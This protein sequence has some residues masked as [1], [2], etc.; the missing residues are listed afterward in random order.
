MAAINLWQ[1]RQDKVVCS[2]TMIICKWSKIRH[3]KQRATNQNI[4]T[5]ILKMI[6]LTSSLT[7]NKITITNWILSMLPLCSLNNRCPRWANI[8]LPKRYQLNLPNPIEVV[9]S[10]NVNK[11]KISKC[12]RPPKLLAPSS[13]VRWSRPIF[14]FTKVNW[15]KIRLTYLSCHKISLTLYILLSL[16]LQANL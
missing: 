13:L 5:P 3:I 10:L 7:N 15:A 8:L 6:A 16:L 11:F 2:S 9:H 1:M 12:P 4:C 14:N